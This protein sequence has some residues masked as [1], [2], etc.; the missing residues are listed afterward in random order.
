M[1][2]YL[3]IVIATSIWVL[4]DAKNIGVK[5]GQIQGLGNLGPW[6]WFF[7]CFLLWIV[8]FP[9]YLA[10][11]SEFKRINSVQESQNVAGGISQAT[12]GTKGMIKCSGCGGEI[13]PKATTCPQCGH[14]N[15]KAKNLS[16]GQVLL[17]IALSGGFIWFFAGGGLDREVAK[18]MRKIENQV[19]ADAVNQYQIAKRQGDPMQICV[20]A[21]FVSAAYLQA[22][23]EPNYQQWK[24]IESEDC[25]R[26]GVPR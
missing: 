10:K 23:D 17:Y 12:K 20:Q 1:N 16:G 14:P 11:R 6:G 18:E 8:G 22:K 7:A 4:V 25:R 3:V 21:G 2:T 26:A 15:E 24:S 19:A 9:F 5:K 13:S